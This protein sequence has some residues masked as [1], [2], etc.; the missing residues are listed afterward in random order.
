MYNSFELLEGID[1]KTIIE[2]FD[3]F[4]IGELNITYERFIFN[5]RK[6]EE[7]ESFELFQ[8]DVQRLMKS[9]KYCDNCKESVLRDK[10]LLGINDSALQRDLLKIRNLTLQQCI[11]TC[12]ANENANL[13]NKM[14]KPESV[15]KITKKVSSRTAK[16]K[17][18]GKYHEFK[19]DKCPAFG[20]IC[21]KC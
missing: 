6:Q 2:H 20:K 7:G 13:Q 8:A 16:C 15:N 21:A 5:K 12:R 10:I 3:R 4:I 14:M 17:F 9:C 18:C 1:V 11:D 19:K